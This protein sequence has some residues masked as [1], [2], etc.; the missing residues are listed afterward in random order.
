M[1]PEPVDAADPAVRE[2]LRQRLFGERM[3]SFGQ[4]YL[5]ELLGDAII[6]E[7]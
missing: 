2:E 3:Q 5:Q 1:R 7:R 6:I 4:G